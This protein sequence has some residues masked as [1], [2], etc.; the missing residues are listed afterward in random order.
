M[1]PAEYIIPEHY[2][3]NTVHEMVF[4]IREEGEDVNIE[5]TTISARFKKGSLTGKL[6][7]EFTLNDG[8]SLVNAPLGIFRMDSYINDWYAGIYYYDVTITFPSGLIRTY[9]KGTF[10]IIQN[11]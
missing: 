8:I 6:E 4:T 3:G 2:K 9:F 11:S 1:R 5:D 10:T 7:K